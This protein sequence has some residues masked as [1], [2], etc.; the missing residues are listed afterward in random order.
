V[1]QDVTRALN[2]KPSWDEADAALS[3]KTEL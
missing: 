1:E 2:L 3:R